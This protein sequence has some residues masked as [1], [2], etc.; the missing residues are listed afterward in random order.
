MEVI[1]SMATIVGLLSNF[2]SE[3]R[4][5]SDDEYKEFV[6]WLDKKRH[7]TLIEEINSN[8]LLG[9]GIKALLSKNHES[10]VN[11]LS[12]LDDSLETLA[13]QIDGFKDKNQES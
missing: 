10:V 6:E 11:K 4:A 12:A 9:L 7:V 1:S 5:T 8:H 3:R 2:K 13:S